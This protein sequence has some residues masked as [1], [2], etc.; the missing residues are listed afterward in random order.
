MKAVKICVLMLFVFASSVCFASEVVPDPD[1]TTGS[2][3]QMMSQI[4]KIIYG[5]VLQGGLIERLA[6]VEEDLFGRSL[7]GTMAERHAAILNF[8]DIGTDEQPSMMFKLAIAE[9]IVDKK[10]RASEPAARRLE[11]LEVN[12]TGASRGGNPIVMRVESLLATLVMDPVTARPVNLPGDTVMKFRFMDELTPATSRVGDFVRLELTND[13]IVN[14]CLVAPAGSLLITEVRDVKR[15]RMFGVPG[16]VRL[17]FNELKPLGTQRPLV[18]I[19]KESQNAIKEARKT[20]DRGEGA[21]IGAGAA[22][23]AGA[24]LLGPVGLVSGVFIRGNS[25][26][27]PVGAVTFLQTSGDCVVS[28]YPI[29]ISLQKPENNI[30][31]SMPNEN[32]QQQGSSYNPDRDT[33]IK[34]DV[35]N[36]N[37]YGEPTNSGTVN[38]GGGNFELPPEQ[39]VN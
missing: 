20:G 11:D 29:P 1:L 12:L 26:K 8:L 5:Y 36:R 35:F 10:I 34:R 15:P 18:Y 25:L 28:A 3:Q 4:E 13:L 30:T 21:V 23:I 32:T 16:E 22:S 2:S 19:G 31:S 17:S 9:W 33:I 27:I 24:A 38:N 7:P 37:S 14:Q 39:S 6:K